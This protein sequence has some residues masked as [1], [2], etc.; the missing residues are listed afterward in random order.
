MTFRRLVLL[1][2]GSVAALCLVGAVSVLVELSYRPTYDRSDPT[3]HR[4]LEAFERLRVP[5]DQ[6]G[7]KKKGRFC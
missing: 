7:T 5:L 6:R 2:I 3:Y 1:V 4:Y